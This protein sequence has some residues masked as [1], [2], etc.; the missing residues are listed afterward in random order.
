[1]T[2][3]D[4]SGLISFRIDWFDLLVFCQSNIAPYK[5]KQTKSLFKVISVAK[6]DLNS[7]LLQGQWWRG[8]G[9]CFID[10]LGYGKIIGGGH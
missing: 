1:M 6:G 3:E 4:Y 7:I 5:V 2:I 8:A 9:G 10:G